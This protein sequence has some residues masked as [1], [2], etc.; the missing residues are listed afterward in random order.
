MLWA[1]LTPLLTFAVYAYVFSAILEIRF[2]SRVPDVEHNYGIVLFSGLMLHFFITEVLTRSPTLILENVNFVKKVVFP[3]ETL[4]VVAVGSAVVT[5]GFNLLVL[6]LALL[7]FEAR[8]PATTLLVPV[9]WL[10]FVGIVLGMSWFLSSIGV[11]LRDVGHLIGIVSTI[12]LFGSPILF[13][14]E[15][16]PPTLQTLI[17]LNPLSLPVEATRDLVLW[18]VLPSLRGF[19][20]YCAVAGAV[21]WLGA[22]WFQCTKRGF[23]D[24][25]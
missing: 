25:L 12:M 2:P 14:V 7:V 11:Y 15:T 16:L 20:I 24:V 21:I 1:L 6:L 3:L 8:I 5:L 10:P 18:G 17:W 22:Y 13:P 4:S 23:A 19:A 9:V